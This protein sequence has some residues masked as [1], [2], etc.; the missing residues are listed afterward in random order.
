ML[1]PSGDATPEDPRYDTALFNV[2]LGFHHWISSR[3]TNF[4]V[5]VHVGDREKEGTSMMSDITMLMISVVIN[6]AIIM[7]AMVLRDT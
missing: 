4:H 6:I 2:G 1:S 7:L 3:Y 5:S